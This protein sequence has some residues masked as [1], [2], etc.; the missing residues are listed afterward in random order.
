M[1]L[2]TTTWTIRV[3]GANSQRHMLYQQEKGICYLSAHT[4]LADYSKAVTLTSESL[5][6]EFREA[7][8]EVMRRRHGD[9]VELIV[10]PGGRKKAPDDQV[11][12]ARIA[13]RVFAPNKMPK[14]VE[15]PT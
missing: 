6:R 15:V 3:E 14:M 5:A 11:V 4:K 8:M 13:Q 2:K 10:E 12:A 1:T 9:E 7:V